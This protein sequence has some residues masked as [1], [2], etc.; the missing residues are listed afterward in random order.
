MS[1]YA[2]GFYR[3][4]DASWRTAY[5]EKTFE[6]VKKHGGKFFVR[7]HC[8]WEVLGGE[9]PRPTGMVMIELPSMDQAR[10]WYN[11]PD[12]APLRTLR[13]SGSKLDLLLVESLA[14]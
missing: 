11:D 7:P 2:V 5:R 12:Y 3:I 9:P 8:P 13:Q 10:A 14:S 1:A 6:L 4:W